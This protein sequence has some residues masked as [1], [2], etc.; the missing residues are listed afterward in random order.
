SWESGCGFVPERTWTL[1]L[2]PDLCKQEP[3]QSPDGYNEHAA[4]RFCEIGR[5]CEEKGDFDM[6]RACYE[7][8]TRVCPGSSYAALASVKLAAVN[9]ARGNQRQTLGGYEATEEP[10]VVRTEMIPPMRMEPR[11][12]DESLSMLQQGER[13]ER[14]GKMDGAYRC[15]QDAYMI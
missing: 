11:R 13:Y 9:N 2:P 1:D 6:A 3:C 8:A 4:K 7:E 15:Y 12:I 14:E 5:Q 10:P